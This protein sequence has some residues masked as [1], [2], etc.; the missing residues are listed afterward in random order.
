MLGGGIWRQHVDLRWSKRGRIDLVIK[1]FKSL[2]PKKE[3]TPAAPESTSTST[4]K[5]SKKNQQPEAQ[6]TS[7]KEG[8]VSTEFHF[9]PRA[10][11]STRIRLALPAEITI[12][13]TNET[14]AAT[15]EIVNRRGARMICSSPMTK[16]EEVRIKAPLTGKT[17]DGTVV[18]ANPTPNPDGKFEFA[19]ELKTQS[20]PFAV[21][22]PDDPFS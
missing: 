12:V 16:H 10:N 13:R 4:G 6:R 2:M 7:I 9:S 3:Q 5:R 22:F 19:I 1:F 18:W 20:N 15:T 17:A 14:V 21:H 8:R 11:R